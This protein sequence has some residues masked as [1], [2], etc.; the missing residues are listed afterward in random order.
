MMINYLDNQCFCTK[1]ND[2]NFVKVVFAF[3]GNCSCILIR[4]HRTLFGYNLSS[5]DWKFTL[6][7]MIFCQ[8]VTHFD[9]FLSKSGIMI[10]LKAWG[11]RFCIK[12]NFWFYFEAKRVITF[13]KTWNDHLKGKMWAF[14]VVFKHQRKSCP[15][16][17]PKFQLHEKRKSPGIQKLVKVLFFE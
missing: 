11:R 1:N 12:T 10:F 3:F 8:N 14:P 2:Y 16:L 7:I 6:G 17:F 5:K 15:E 13:P 9:E 4:S